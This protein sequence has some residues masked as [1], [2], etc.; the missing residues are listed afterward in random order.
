MVEPRELMKQFYPHVLHPPEI[1]LTSRYGISMVEPLF[2]MSQ[3]M[4]IDS[5]TKQLA[6]QYPAWALFW[7][8]GAISATMRTLPD[9]DPW[10]TRHPLVTSP[11][12]SQARNSSTPR[13]GSWRDVV[14]ITPPMREDIDVDMDLAFFSDALSDDS[15]KVLV[16]GSRGW[17]TTASV[18]ADC[19]A[20]D[21]EYLFSVGDGALRWA[22]GRRR[23]YSGHGDTFPV[24]SIIQSAA[25]A[26]SII[27]GSHEP[28]EA[29]DNL[30]HR[31]KFSNMAY[32]PL[33][34]EF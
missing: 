6:I 17:K 29:L 4:E 22:I 25:N 32:V 16:A 19:S 2:S 18:L 23:Q 31:E 27:K 33:D 7:F 8:A 34:D 11:L 12:S 5:Q 3:R 20:P 14:D 13:F 30:V 24:T 28:S 26:T 9:N 15:A 1:T 21:G 10:S